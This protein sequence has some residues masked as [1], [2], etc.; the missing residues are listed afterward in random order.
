[1]EHLLLFKCQGACWWAI[2]FGYYLFISGC[3]TEKPNTF[4]IAWSF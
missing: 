4:F 3:L 2:T 1:L